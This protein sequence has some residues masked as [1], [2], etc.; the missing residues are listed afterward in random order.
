M[1]NYVVIS[2]NVV[3]GTFRNKSATC[4]CYSMYVC[5]YVCM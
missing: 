1:T 3:R 4:K 2:K 5:M